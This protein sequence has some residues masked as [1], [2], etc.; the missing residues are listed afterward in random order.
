MTGL[1]SSL[2]MFSTFWIIKLFSSKYSN[3]FQL[4]CLAVLEIQEPLWVQKAPENWVIL[5][6]Y[7]PGLTFHSPISLGAF[8]VGILIQKVLPKS[9]DKE[10]GGRA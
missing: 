6:S 3:L 8:M 10:R 9:K 1:L 4:R 2:S 7:K 5:K